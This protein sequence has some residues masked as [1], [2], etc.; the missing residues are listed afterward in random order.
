MSHSASNRPAESA[1]LVKANEAAE[2]LSCSI[3]GIWRL[4]AADKL[5]RI[6]V[7]HVGVRFR[8][9]DVLRLIEEGGN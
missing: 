3:R 9:A 2:L 5:P 4:A 6:Q 1:R 8:M 7:P